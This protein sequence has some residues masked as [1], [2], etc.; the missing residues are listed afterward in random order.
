[1]AGTMVLYDPD[2]WTIKQTVSMGLTN[3]VK[4]IT[5]D[6]TYFWAIDTEFLYQCQLDGSTLHL[7]QSYDMTGIASGFQALSA[8]ATNGNDLFLAYWTENSFG[9]PPPI[10]IQ[11]AE[12]DI[13]NKEGVR[14]KNLANIS[15]GSQ[16]FTDNEYWDLTYNGHYLLATYQ[17]GGRGLVA[18][19]DP[20]TEQFVRT[21]LAPSVALAK[22]G[23][24]FCGYGFHG[25]A[26]NGPRTII[27]VDEDENN[28]KIGTSVGAVDV[29]GMTYCGPRLFGEADSN[30]M[31]A[32]YGEFVAVVYN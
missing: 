31:L 28:L 2:T 26:D 25:V 11:S 12:V 17:A 24:T 20:H 9:G 21:V 29:Q 8:I 30:E 5:N 32:A 14:L 10:V 3:D 13:I 27:T 19:Y 7:L 4:G 18:W 22:R 23:Y 6:G 1:M 15:V 16:T